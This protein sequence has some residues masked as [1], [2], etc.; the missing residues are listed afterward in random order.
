MIST[1]KRLHKE[2]AQIASQSDENI[3][4]KPKE[5]VFDWDATIRGPVDSYY[6]GYSFDLA[7]HVPQEYPMVPPDIKFKT[8]IFHPNVLFEVSL[9]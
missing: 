7:I 6:E 1:S 8:K 2:A 3:T 9:Q 4:L 5:S